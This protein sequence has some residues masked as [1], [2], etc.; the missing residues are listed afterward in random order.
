MATVQYEEDWEYYVDYT[1]WD[2][3]QTPNPP[4]VVTGTAWFGGNEFGSV[5]IVGQDA[6]RVAGL[7]G[8]PESSAMWIH[9]VSADGGSW[10]PGNE[11]GT[12]CV[13]HGDVAWTTSLAGDASVLSFDIQDI[14]QIESLGELALAGTAPRLH[15]LDDALLV[16]ES[17]R[18]RAVGIGDP[19]APALLDDLGLDGPMLQETIVH[20][21]LLLGTGDDRFVTIDISN[22]ANL[23]LRAD[24]ALPSACGDHLA[25]SGDLAVTGCPDGFQVIDIANPDAPAVLGPEVPTAPDGLAMAGSQVYVALA[26]GD[27]EVYDL[28]EPAA[29]VLAGQVEGATGHGTMVCGET[30]ITGTVVYPLHCADIVG[31]RDDRP[32]APAAPDQITVVPNPFNPQTHVAFELTRSTRVTLAVHDLRGR[33]VR[34][35]AD[36]ELPAGTHTFIWN[37]R[38]DAGRAQASGVY[39]VRLETP[40]RSSTAKAVLVR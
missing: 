25:A 28:A 26:G 39:L 29:P 17:D 31:V 36:A 37:G 35:L 20:G 11:A 2:L 15:V 6:T 14:Q 34:I 23:V 7:T 33:C 38:D 19:T 27:L 13:F 1:V 10:V 5:R 12:V 16:V 9:D 32:P 8:T 22:P 40:S 24:L 4:V 18:V 21:D 3:G 30:L